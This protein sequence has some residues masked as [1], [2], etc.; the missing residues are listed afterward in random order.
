MLI[1]NTALAR[2]AFGALAETFLTGVRSWVLRILVSRTQRLWIIV[3]PEITFETDS[4]V[5]FT[6]HAS[7]LSTSEI[8][9]EGETHDVLRRS[10]SL[11]GVYF[12]S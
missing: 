2:L 1:S 3:D 5:D 12:G 11:L 6:T 10:W 9:F 4:S 8:I 7:E